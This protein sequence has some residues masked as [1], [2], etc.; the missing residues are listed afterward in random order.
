MKRKWF[1]VKTVDD[2]IRVNTTCKEVARQLVEIVTGQYVECIRE[3]EDY[4]MC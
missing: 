2:R 4:E 1:I 3:C